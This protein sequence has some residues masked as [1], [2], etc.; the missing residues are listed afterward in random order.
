[1]TNII[2]NMGGQMNY[3]KAEI[4]GNGQNP[5]LSGTAIFYEISNSGL[6]IEI[7]INNLPDEML[8][9]HSGFFGMHIHEYGD[10]SLPF[11]KTGNHYNPKNDLHSN[12]AGDLPPLLSSNGYAY[13]AF[14]DGRITL[15]EIIGKSLIIHSMSDD[16]TSQPSGNSGTKIACGIII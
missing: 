12:H 13:S 7:E 14:Y 10:C 3:A 9:N 2:N 4:Y 11:D 1:M 6:L 16:F 8:T 15:Q 5:N